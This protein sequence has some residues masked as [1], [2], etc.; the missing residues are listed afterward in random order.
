M[1][2]QKLRRLPVVFLL[3]CLFLATAFQ[4]FSQTRLM[5][6]IN[7]GVVALEGESGI[8]VSWRKF[9]L[10]PGDVAFNVYRNGILLNES[11]V[12]EV[13]NYFDEEGTLESYYYVEV[14]VDG[15]VIE[16]SE[17]AVVWANAHKDIPL[18]TPPGYQP[19][20]ASVADLDGDGELEIVVKMQ[21]TTKDNSQ[22]GYTDPVFLHAYE[23]NGTLLWSIDLGINIRAGAHYTQFMVYD[24]NGDGLAELACKT[25]PGTKDASGSYLSDG[26]AAGDDDL[27][28]YRNSEGYILQ[29]PEYLTLFDGKTGAE[30][31]TVA[32]VPERGN[33]GDWEIL[34]AIG[35][36]ASWPALPILKRRPVW[37]WL[38]DIIRARYW[39]HGTTWT[40]PW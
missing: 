4:A 23:M 19:N 31:S 13:S 22:P 3:S 1:F 25:A 16:Q 35:S 26:P 37:S 11:P 7:R 9:A 29:G 20:D 33:V 36:T 5:E 14:L 38:G 12:T 2:T 18:Q 32:Y 30:I 40:E 6:S 27:A 15:E 34:T 24:L 39:P 21:G 8:F 17:P 10:D 28:D